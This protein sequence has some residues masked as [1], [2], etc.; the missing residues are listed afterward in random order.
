MDENLDR[1]GPLFRELLAKVQP[2][3]AK[4]LDVP[5]EKVTLQARFVEDLGAD[6][7]D[8]VELLLCLEEE[9]GIRI[10][11]EEAEKFKTVTDLLNCLQKIYP[12]K[13]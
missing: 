9:F 12:V 2:V 13:K 8:T 10:P 7:L 6:S 4:E 3:I 11:T 5:I 1:S